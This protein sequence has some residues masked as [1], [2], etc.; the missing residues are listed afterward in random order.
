MAV[1]AALPQPFANGL[2][3]QTLFSVQG[4]LTESVP[5]L[6]KESLVK[7]LEW[8]KQQTEPSV[9]LADRA[10]LI[11]NIAKHLQTTLMAK[12]A[13]EMCYETALLAANQSEKLCVSKDEYRQTGIDAELQLRKQIGETTFEDDGVTVVLSPLEK[14]QGE[15]SLLRQWKEK[16]E[17]VLAMLKGEP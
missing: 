2:L 8:I 9:S 16:P 3:I 1:R 15:V 13:I 17:L 14:I 7:G 12:E 6:R 11:K 10:T 4:P 5:Y